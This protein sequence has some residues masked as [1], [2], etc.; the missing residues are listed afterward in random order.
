VVLTL[1]EETYTLEPKKVRGVIA[2]DLKENVTLKTSGRSLT[3][4]PLQQVL[5]NNKWVTAKNLKVGDLVAVSK[6]LNFGRHRLPDHEI[7]LLSIWLAEGAGY[8][9]TNQTPEIIRVMT[10]AASHLGLVPAAKDGLQWTFFNGDRTGGPQA[11]TKNPLR[12][13]LEGHGLWRCNSKTKFVPPIVFRL[14]EDQIS[15]FL[16]LFMACDGCVNRRSKN[17][18]AIEIGLANE[19]LVRQ[20]AKLFHKY[21]IRGQISHKVHR[22]VSRRDG[23]P[24]QSWRF[25][26][27]DPGCIES[28]ASRI[29]ALSK[30]S[31]TANARSAA[32]RSRGNCNAYL[33]I[34][35]DDFIKH[36][37]YTPVSKGKFGGYNCVVSRDLPPMLRESLNTWRKQTRYR[38]SMRRYN[39]LRQFTDGFFAHLVDRDVAWEEITAVETAGPVT[40]T[41][42]SI[43][44]GRCY[45][46]DGVF[47]RRPSIESRRIG[48]F[49]NGGDH[50]GFQ[51][52]LSF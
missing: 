35:H 24:F 20:L 14:E 28:F 9:I 19:L 3:C 30:E 52:D 17:T 23:E 32:A 5:A 44:D 2:V 38:T 27:S 36:L 11:G 10:K 42:L 13:M 21:G 25:I 33:P 41:R 26:T 4:P 37:V 49:A 1:D 47:T 50:R 8:Q 22:A 16:N 48:S 29:G 12:R 43:Q 15:R 34:S 7:D 6:R 18:W 51:W 46:A 31:Q 40:M 39:S 45:I